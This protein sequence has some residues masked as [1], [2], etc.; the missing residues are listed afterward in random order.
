M[1]G[2]VVGKGSG[3]RKESITFS[4]VQFGVIP[5]VWSPC[6]RSRKDRSGRPG[7][8]VR[9]GPLYGEVDRSSGTEGDVSSSGAVQG[10]CSRIKAF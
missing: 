5:C 7:D 1:C 2:A 8:A 4:A 3:L 6:R 10:H 9:G